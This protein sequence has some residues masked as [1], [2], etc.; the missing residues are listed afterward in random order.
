MHTRQGDRRATGAPAQV[1]KVVIPVGKPPMSLPRHQVCVKPRHVASA[2]AH[3]AAAAAA[4]RSRPAAT[5][6]RPHVELRRVDQDSQLQTMLF[7]VALEIGK[8]ASLQC[9]GSAVPSMALCGMLNASN[10]RAQACAAGPCGTDLKE[11]VVF[12]PQK[13]AQ[14]LVVHLQRQRR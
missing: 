10:H 6:R 5:I 13:A 4:G 14:P 3:C 7:G 8:P 9:T 1:I 11:G 12:T 2:M